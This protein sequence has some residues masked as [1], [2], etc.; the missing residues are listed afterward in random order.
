MPLS[1][2]SPPFCCKEREI[3]HSCAGAVGEAPFPDRD[4]RL[5]PSAAARE[6]A[7]LFSADQAGPAGSRCKDTT[8][9]DSGRTVPSLLRLPAHLCGDPGSGPVAPFEAPR[10]PSPP[11]SGR[12]G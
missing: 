12:A 5:Q 4:A 11:R 6:W 2:A 1:P 8:G 3:G 7:L 10:S 9:I